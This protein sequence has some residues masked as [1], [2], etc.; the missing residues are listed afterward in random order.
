MRIAARIEP[1]PLA[2]QLLARWL[3]RL[4]GVQLATLA[5]RVAHSVCMNGHCLYLSKIAPD[6]GA[7]A[8]LDF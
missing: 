7:E 2:I 1:L 5:Y 4:A 3:W 6:D 8:S